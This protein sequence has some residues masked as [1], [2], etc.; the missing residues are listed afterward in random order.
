MQ[1]VDSAGNPRRIPAIQILKD[2][3]EGMLKFWSKFGKTPSDRIGMNILPVKNNGM[4]SRKRKSN[5]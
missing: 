1:Y 5:G 3:R 2:C 4:A